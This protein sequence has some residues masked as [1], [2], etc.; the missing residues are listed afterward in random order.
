MKTSTQTTEVA[1]REKVCCA[2]FDPTLWNNV[3]RSWNDKLFMRSYI[4]ELFHMPLP[5][6][7]KKAITGMWKKAEEAGAAPDPADFLLLSYD[8][9]PFKGELLMSVTKEVPDADVV[10]LSGTFISKVFDGPY[11]K[12]PKYMSDMND[13][14]ESVGKTPHKIY[15]Y[16]PY[17]PK[18]AKKYGHNYIVA[19]AEV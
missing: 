19:L 15:F 16:F 17:C 7:Y 10:K 2:E 9:S 4:N 5:G 6:A 8:I 18:C 12:V 11:N 3:T 1:D 14:L 13:Y